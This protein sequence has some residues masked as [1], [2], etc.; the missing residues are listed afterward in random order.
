MSSL[1][2]AS[3]TPSHAGFHSDKRRGV[4][5][6]LLLVSLASGIA[7]YTIAQTTGSQHL[8]ADVTTRDAPSQSLQYGTPKD[9]RNA[10]K[11]LQLTFS[12][13]DIVS[14]DADDLRTHGGSSWDH[15]TGVYEHPSP[16]VLHILRSPRGLPSERH[17]VSTFN[18]RCCSNCQ[19]CHEVSHTNNGVFRCNEFGGANSKCTDIITYV[20]S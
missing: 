11:E 2:N 1:G 18:R 10:I 20:Y 3:G 14:T 15:R 17:S 6:R 8:L 7:G 19:D 9:V 16:S 4:G 13:A 12:S 5:A